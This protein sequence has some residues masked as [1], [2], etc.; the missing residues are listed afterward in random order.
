MIAPVRQREVEKAR[1]TLVRL[2]GLKGITRKEIQRRLQEQGHRI[3]ATRVLRGELDLKLWQLVAILEVLEMAP[4][5]FFK[6]TFREPKEHSPF[7][8]QLEAMMAPFHGQQ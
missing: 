5:E 4:L 2:V 7:R 3:D 6:L 1:I 8:L